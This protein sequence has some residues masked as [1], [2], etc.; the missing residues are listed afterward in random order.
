M[1]VTTGDWLIHPPL[2]EAWRAKLV[3]A[4][5]EWARTHPLLPGMPRQAATTSLE[6]PDPSILD[7][8]VG[9]EPDLVVDREGVHIRGQQATLPAA[10]QQQLD[11]ILQRLD[12][13]PF[14]APDAPEL[15]AAGLSEKIVAVATRDGRL[16]CIAPGV[17]LRPSALDEAMR[18]L[19]QLKQPFTMAEARQAL[20]TTRRVAVP[21]LELLDSSRR[22]VR[23]NSQLRRVQDCA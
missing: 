3:T 4:A 19:S 15:A 9:E 17:Y 7:D 11:R 20:S 2:W 13:D 23:V 5:S 6:L 12:A 8:L 21:L 10:A 16:V 1:A 18:R 14:D 22:T